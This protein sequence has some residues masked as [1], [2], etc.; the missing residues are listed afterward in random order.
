[1]CPQL[2]PDGEVKGSDAQKTSALPEL[3]PIEQ[4]GGQLAQN[5]RLNDMSLGLSSDAHFKNHL[6]GCMAIRDQ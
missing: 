5:I 3:F 2:I 4:K 6:L 1:V